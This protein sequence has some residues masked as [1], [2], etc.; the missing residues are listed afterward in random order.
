MLANFKQMACLKSLFSP[1]AA[2]DRT[3]YKTL[4]RAIQRHLIRD[5]VL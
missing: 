5:S 2:E 1:K 4:A 3:H